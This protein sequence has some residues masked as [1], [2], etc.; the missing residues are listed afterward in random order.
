LIRSTDL[1]IWDEAP[2]QHRHIHEAV[3]RTF[4]DIRHSDKP[5]GGLTIVFGGDFKQ[6]LPVVVKGSRP[7][8]VGACIQKS[9]LWRSVKVLKLTENMRLNTEVEA[10]RNFAKWQLE[11]G[12]GK[13]T[14][15]ATGNLKLPN[16][17]KCAENTISS[18][19]STVYSGFNELPLPPDHYFAE[20]TILTSRNDDVDDIN[21]EML[22]QFPGEEKQIFSADSIKGNNKNGEGELLYPVEYLNSINCSGLPLH[23]L[24]LKVGCPVMILRNLNPGEGVCNGSR[25][26]VTQMSNR[27]LEV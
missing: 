11:I 22:S 2:M 14:D 21:E 3:D 24:Q 23:K 19:I 8:I 16:H 26:I 7:Q 27:V 20:R 1:V 17:F 10:E 12:H 4:Q 13:H 6:I 18:L 25:E 5:F 9:H 15:P